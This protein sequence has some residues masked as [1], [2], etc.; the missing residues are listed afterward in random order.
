MQAYVFPGQ[1]AQFEGMGSDLYK[2]SS[3]ARELF[4][5]A[6]DILKFSISKSMFNGTADDLKLTHLAQPAIFLHSLITLYA[7]QT[8]IQPDAVAGHSLG[9]M[10]ALVAARV[11][12]FEAGLQLV[13]KRAG[14]MQQCCKIT[15]GTMLAVIGF[16]DEVT[17]SICSEIEDVVV[18]ANY[19]THGQLVISGTVNGV[20]QAAGRLKEA[21]ARMLVELPVSGGFHSPLMEDAKV[22][23]AEAVLD[24]E[25]STPSCPVYQN[26]SAKAETDPGSIRDNIVQQLTA[27]VR[28]TQTI[29]QMLV[30]GVSSFVEVGGKG[31]I[32][33]G[34]IKKINRKIAVETL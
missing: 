24:V 17:E 10:T 13:A 7:R 21:G 30:D 22:E 14:V 4:D 31:G 27:P 18:P 34:F 15:H 29:E 32:L 6:D 33:R 9:E 16:E 12:S 19:N 2:Q 28:W 1:G 26:V 8:D 23:F 5:K 11:L 3:I 25:F 20:A